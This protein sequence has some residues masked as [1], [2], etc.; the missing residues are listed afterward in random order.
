M[1]L[2]IG[3]AA[4]DFQSANAVADQI[5]GVDGDDLMT[6]GPSGG[7]FQGTGLIGDPFRDPIRSPSGID[8]ME[9][10]LGNDAIYGFDGNDILYGG[11][12]NESGVGLNLVRIPY[13]RHLGRR[14]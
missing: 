5:Y 10:G 7:A 14:R 12:G 6:G 9:G 13:S 1:A 3:T 11:D 2:I 8:Y 4:G